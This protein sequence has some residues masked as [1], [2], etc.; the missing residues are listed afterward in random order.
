MLSLKF[1][2]ELVF[3]ATLGALAVMG[4]SRAFY[5]GRL[6]RGWAVLFGAAWGVSVACLTLTAGSG[7]GM[8]LNLVPFRVDGPGTVLDST[9]NVAMFI[10]LGLVFALRGS[11]FRTAL[12]GALACTLFIEVTQYISDVGRTADIND[13]ITNVTGGCF[14]WALG[15][16]IQTLTSRHRLKAAVSHP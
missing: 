15:R 5:P 10:P 13:V 6:T 8:R 16:C 11:H 3:M 9:L 4:L 14:G 2:L 7:L 1:A 12:L